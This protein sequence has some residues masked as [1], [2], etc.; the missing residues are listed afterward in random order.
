[1]ANSDEAVQQALKGMGG[2][3]G[4]NQ[5]KEEQKKAMDEARSAILS[6]ILTPEARE[7]LG[8]IMLV[9]PDKAKS[10]EDALIKAAQSGQLSERVSDAKLVAM[11]DQNAEKKSTKITYQRKKYMDDDDDY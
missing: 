6:Q 3:G 4:D 9:K 2:G 10:L 11:L 1:M 8:R 5:Q 7:R